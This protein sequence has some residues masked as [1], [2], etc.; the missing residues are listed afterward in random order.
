MESGNGVSTKQQRIAGN[1]EIMPKV[2]FTA[3][4]HH[5]DGFWMYE[6]Y[7]RTRKSGAVGIDKVTAKDYEKELASNLYDLNER[8]KSGTYR[9]PAVRRVHIP[10]AGGKETRPIGI[11]TFE[12]KVLQRAVAMVIE[13]IYEKDFYASSFGFRPGKSQHQAMQAL[14]NAMRDVRGGYIIDLDIRKFFDTLDHGHLRDIL[15]KR[16]RDGVIRKLIDKWLKAGVME[17]GV[18]HYS[19]TGTP[20]GGVI[21]PLLS[22]IYLH[23][24]LDVWFHEIV[25]PRLKGRSYLIRY[26][27]DA[28]IVFEDKSDS[29]RVMAVLGKRFEKYG[30]TLHPDKT[31]LLDMR[32]PRGSAG[33]RSDGTEPGTFSFLGFTYHWAR[34]ANGY[35]VLMSKTAKDRL[36][37]ALAKI[38]EWVRRNRH[39]PIEAQHKALGVKLKGHYAYYGVTGN[40]RS[41]KRFYRA[42]VLLWFKWL[43]QRS[44]NRNLMIWRFLKRLK[45]NPL[46]QPKIIHKF[47]T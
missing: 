17:D 26:A 10:K 46:P 37:R 14:W 29:E 23:E 6:A 34:S 30:L 9:A 42:V 13:P 22:N 33:K 31:K 25:R 18:V 7:R 24:V 11:P 4:A 47:A 45:L 16:I 8:A 39:E 19:E 44:R 15:D 40:F 27:D 21:S 36:S 38:K 3:L 20:Q 28:I 43:N 5:M 12:D 32:R 1:A 35:W 41:L 2:A